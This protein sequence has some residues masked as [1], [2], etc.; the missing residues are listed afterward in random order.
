MIIVGAYTFLYMLSLAALT[1]QNEVSNFHKLR[2][3]IAFI[4]TND[5]YGAH[6]PKL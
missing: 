3:T 1:V 5:T 4:Q 6:I 2:E